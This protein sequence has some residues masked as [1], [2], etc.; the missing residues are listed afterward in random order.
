MFGLF[1][2]YFSND[3][4]IDLGTANTLIYMRDKGIVLDEP[5]V[6]AIRQEGGPNGKKT[7]LAVGKEAK[8]MLGRVPGNI[9]AIRPMKDGVIADFTITEQM[10]KQFIKMVH[11]TK[12]LKP[13]PRIIIC[14]PCGSTQV[15]RRA[16]RE[17]ALGAGASQVYLIE[18]PMAAAIGAGLPVSEASGSMVVDIGGGTTEVGVMSLGGMVYKGSVRVG[19]DKF[20]EAIIN[21]IRRNYGMLI[22]EQTAESIKKTIGSAFPGAEVRD[23]EIRG[24]NLSEGIPRS[25]TVTS[26]E[27]LEALT[28]PLNQIV[29]AVKVALEQT[30][31]ELASDIADRGMM[32]TGGGALLRDLDRLLL[33]ETGLPVH[34]AEDPLTCVV[35]GSGIALERMDKLGGV[36]S[37][38]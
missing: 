16:I 14:V 26:N 34:V 17:S 23:M 21:Y 32:L 30:P 19:G 7:I 10:L 35:R 24:R 15:E 25:F 2:N 5:S 8:Q 22:G 11:E 20:D 12:L 38:E 33:E 36:F 31:P 4:A 3:L 28:D 1:R 9:E 27:I 18:E 13:S 29:T 37:Q 6:V